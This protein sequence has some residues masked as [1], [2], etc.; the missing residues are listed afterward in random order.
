MFRLLGVAHQSS[1][2]VVA[3]LAGGRCRAHIDTILGLTLPVLFLV[4]VFQFKK[5]GN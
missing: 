5:T 3:A 1:A 2:S 4:A